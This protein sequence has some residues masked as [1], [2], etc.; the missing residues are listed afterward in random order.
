MDSLTQ[1]VVGIATAEAVLGKQ[2]KNK[3]FIYGAIIGTLP[4]LDIWFGK[5]FDPLTAI[6]IHRGLSHSII[7]YLFL[8]VFLGSL[9]FKIEKRKIKLFH[10]TQATFL[11]LFTHSII[12]AFTTWGTQIF[13]PLPYKV[14]LKS[15]FVIDIF[16]TIPWII[17]LYFVF[18]NQDFI[19]RKK[20]LIR[21]FYITTAYLILGLGIKT[22]VVNKFEKALS[23]QNIEYTEIIVKPTFSNIIL[24]NANVMTKDSFLLADYSLFDSK[25]IIFD[26]YLQNE[27]LGNSYKNHPEFKQLI[28]ISEGWYTLEKSNNGII[29]NDLR[30]GLLK[31]EKNITKFTFSYELSKTDINTLE[32]KEIKKENKDGKK[33]L[34]K[35]LKRI[36]G[37]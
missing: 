8:S 21:G 24:W 27:N 37:N 29:F 12:D 18:K 9:I 23:S 15:I 31:K 4:D 16:Y 2:L 5:L 36:K 14:A 33:F 1:I 6:S 10:A 20:W 32:I 17:C 11:I 22:Y 3:S 19:N 30:F 13:W 25:P 28:D 26:S 35:I 7:F 34:A